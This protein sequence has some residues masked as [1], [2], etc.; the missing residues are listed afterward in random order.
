M[1]SRDISALLA[2]VEQL[3]HPLPIQEA[4]TG[5]M[6]QQRGSKGI[7]FGQHSR[8]CLQPVEGVDETTS[9]LSMVL[10]K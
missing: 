3:C 7:S 10:F 8:G 9:T 2:Y 5:M 4:A 6:G 1:S